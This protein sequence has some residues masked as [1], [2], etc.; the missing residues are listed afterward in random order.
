ME[1]MTRRVVDLEACAVKC[2]RRRDEIK[3]T[4]DAVERD[5]RALELAER[6]KRAAERLQA[7]RVLAD[8]RK[9][10][11]DGIA[12]NRAEEG[13]VAAARREAASLATIEARLSAA[14]PQ[15]SIA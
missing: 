8:E 10:L 7:A 1:E 12:N 15:V 4:L 13:L 3:S 14:S 2:R 5:R 6:A 11:T 9:V